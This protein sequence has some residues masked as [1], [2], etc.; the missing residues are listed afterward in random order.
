MVSGTQ[1]NRRQNASRLA[2]WFALSFLI[3]APAVVLLVIITVTPD[4]QK[5][6]D[7]AISVTLAPET[8]TRPQ[9]VPTELQ[10]PEAASPEK[11]PA[12]AEDGM[13]PATRLRAAEVLADPRSAGVRR[14][15]G[16]LAPE[17]R[18]EQICNLEAMEQVH[19][20]KPAFEPDF[21]VAYALEDTRI[22]GREIRADGAAI[23]I[24]ERWFRLRYACAMTADTATVAHFSFALGA[25]I[26]RAEWADHGLLPASGDMHGD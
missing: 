14:D 15:L 4:L 10:A 20:W 16:T 6:E 23:R 21:L 25:E 7:Q 11:P 18:L 22:E 5:P 2:P 24:A 13:I 3:H 1:G 8:Q 12:P 9:P 26:P 19:L 17:T